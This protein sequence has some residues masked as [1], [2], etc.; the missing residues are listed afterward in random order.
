MNVQAREY[1]ERQTAIPYI[2]TGG[3]EKLQSSSVAVV[4]VGGVGSAAAYYLSKSGIGHLRLVDQDILETSNLHRLHGAKLEDLYHPKAEVLARRLSELHPWCRNEP[5]VETLTQ[6]NVAE[7]LQGVE[8]VLDGLDNFRTR[9]VLNRFA[10]RTGTPYLFASSIADQ[11]HLALFNPPET[12]CLECVMPGVY[13][14]SDESCEVLGV[15]PSVIGLAGSTA[16]GVAVRFLLG[17]ST[18]LAG[19]LMNVDMAGPDVFFTKLLKR[20]RCNCC[21][22][23]G[24]RAGESDGVV[25]LLCGESTANVLPDCETDLDLSTISLRIAPENLL[26]GTNSVVV[27]RK[28]LFTISLFRNGRLLIGGVNREEEAHRVAR[29]VW[30]ELFGEKTLLKETLG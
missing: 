7:L 9:Y 10:V 13:D 2:G 5:I 14:R 20:D 3:L 17:L 26:V 25:T 23:P 6:R 11:A 30:D 8:L 27:Y 1:F 22:D 24:G 28:G 21:N 29:E 15:S 19:E 18:R 4:G 12:P 16:A